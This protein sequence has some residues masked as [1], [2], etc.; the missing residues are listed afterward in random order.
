MVKN[1]EVW[2]C[3]SIASYNNEGR[4]IVFPWNVL[5]NF[6]IIANMMNK[7]II[8]LVFL[9]ISSSTLFAQ[10]TGSTNERS[11]V[12]EEGKT[13]FNPH[14]FLS[15]QGGAAYTLGE[16]DLETCSHHQLQ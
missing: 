7:N 3:E 9:F 1:T 13:V 8:L 2:T 4:S 10:Q 15:V 14:W 6:E 12:K 16:A 5:F 11:R